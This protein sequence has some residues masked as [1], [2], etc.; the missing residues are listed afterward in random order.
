MKPNPQRVFVTG[1]AGFIGSHL[2]NA[3]LA[4]GHQVTVFDNL[5][6]GLRENIPDGVKL[7]VGDILDTQSVQNAIAGHDALIHLAARVAI[8]SSFEFAIEDT[9][10]NVVGTAS[11]MR[12][13]QLAGGVKRA[14]AA[15]SMA[16]YADAPSSAPIAE[17]HPTAPVSPYGI[18][19]LALEQLIH[20]MASNA[21][22]SSAVLRLFN[23]YGPR[24]SLSPYVG[25]VTIFVNKLLRGEAPTVFGDGEQCRDFVH[26]EDVANAFV[27]AVESDVNGETFNIGTSH[28]TSVNDILAQLMTILRADVKPIHLAAVP[29]ELRF[30]VANIAKAQQLLNYHPVHVLATALAPVVEEI[31]AVACA[32]SC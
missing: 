21:G 17:T 20:G 27:S 32:S 15:S 2:V 11:V 26:V 18:S 28:A 24:Q 22:M 12:A 5:S 1:G 6:V 13:A 25:V 19:K 14:I 23:T 3:L 30:S 7:I 31:A 8:R 9:S 4:R 10:T 16:V 29:G